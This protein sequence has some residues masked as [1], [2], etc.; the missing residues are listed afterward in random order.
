MSD[1]IEFNNTILDIHTAK[2]NFASDVYKI[3]L[4]N[5]A[6]NKATHTVKADLAEIAAGNGYPALGIAV[7]ISGVT[8]TAGELSIALAQ[9]E[10]IIAAGGSIGAFRYAVL[11]N[12]THASKPLVCYWDYSTSITL[13]DGEKLDLNLPAVLIT[14][15]LTK[16]A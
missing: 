9:D 11:Y 8:Q 14:A 7:N 15:S 13:L 16:A 12:A 4:T 1:F 10:V 6:P 2:H 3:Y 5:A